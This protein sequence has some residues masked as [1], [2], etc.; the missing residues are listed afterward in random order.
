MLT[1]NNLLI[2]ILFFSHLILINLYP[3]N[4]EH[5]FSDFSSKFIIN[6]D[7][8]ITNYYRNQANTIIYPLIILLMEILIPF[9]DAS[10]IGKLI[11]SFGS[12][13]L[14]LAIIRFA[15]F[16]SIQKITILIFIICLNPFVWTMAHRG[17]PDFIAP[18]LA[19]FSV[20]FLIVDQNILRKIFFS[21]L[22][23]V[24]IAIKP[25]VGIILIYLNIHFLFKNNF[26]LIKSFKELLIINIISTLILLL[27]L[28]F[29]Y[30]NFNFFLTPPYFKQSLIIDN[31]YLFLNNFIL[32]I[33]YTYMLIIPLRLSSLFTNFKKKIVIL[34]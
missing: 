16:Y 25:T 8:A 15:K 18:S 21:V 32:Y 20:S 28:I 10:Q 11:S 6:P 26:N 29:I 34:I 1:K 3:V 22:L 31:M 13:L 9:L 19:I 27:Y 14:G 23:G 24:A 4:F 2:F 17:T 33:G 12:I 7:E 5:T 30:Y